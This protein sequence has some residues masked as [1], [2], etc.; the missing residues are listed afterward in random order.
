MKSS[1]YLKLLVVV[2]AFLV[3]TAVVHT[4]AVKKLDFSFLDLM[5][6]SVEP[7]A[8][9]E[10]V[11][12]A[13]DQYSLSVFGWPVDRGL[14]GAM[15]SVLTEAGAKKSVLIFFSLTERK[16]RIQKH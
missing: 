15:I 10:S 7:E 9:A 2:A 16:K 1:P 12:I 4:P 11:L 3:G 8:P 6:I 14:Y 13:V 5:M